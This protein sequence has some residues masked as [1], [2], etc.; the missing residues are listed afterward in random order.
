MTAE[1]SSLSVLNASVGGSYCYDCK[2]II[3]V[4]AKRLRSWKYCFNCRDII[5]V[6]AKRLH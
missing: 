4:G 3:T 5:T 1:T 6:G 2:D